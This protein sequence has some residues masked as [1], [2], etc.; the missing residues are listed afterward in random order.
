[1]A[2]RGQDINGLV[3]A[4]RAGDV[5][6]R[7]FLI[8]ALAMGF[9]LPVARAL[10]AQN[11]AS[12]AGGAPVSRHVALAQEPKK[13][14]QVIVGL[15]QEPTKFNP[16]ISTLEVDRGVQFAVFDSLWRIGPD[17]L[18]IPNLATEVPTLDNG[19]ISPDALTYTFKLRQD[20]KWHDGTPLTARDVIFT[21]E[22]IMDPNIPSPLKLGHDK[23]ASIEA[24]DDYT[25]TLTLTEPYAPFLIIWGDTYIV[26]EHILKDQDFMTSEFTSM[27]P[28]GSGPFIFA[29]RTAGEA[30]T[31]EANPNYHGPGPYLDKL[32]FKYIQDT[33][34]LYTQFKTGEI[35]VTGIQFITANHLE[36]A[37][38]LPGKVIHLGQSA[39]V[40]FIYPNFGNP[41]L[42]DKAVREAMYY[43]MDK[44]GIINAIYYGVHAPAE[45][46]LAQT[47]WAYNPNLPKHEYNPDKAR[48]VLDAAGWAPGDDGIRQKDGLRLS[49]RNS[50]T[51]GNALRE[52][53][54]QYL[55]QTW[56]D[57]GIE[58]TIENFP[59]AVVWG[60][61]YNKSQ[62]DTVMIG[63]IAGPGGD[64]DV[65]TRFHSSQIPVETGAG[66]N[67]K[68]YKNPE[69][70]RLLEEGAREPDQE[71]RKQIYFRV[72]EI[73]RED[74]AVL[75]IFHYVFIEGTKEG[76][77][78]FKQNA[79]VV[80]N[81]WNVYEWYWA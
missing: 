32:I 30:I 57:V 29:S 17:G 15:T 50:T 25:I 31:L 27:K 7:E 78:N 36:E 33:E 56:K 74:L 13:G 52:Q 44:E 5:S 64:P 11:T 8:R 9:S 49:F 54:Q 14:G 37:K 1:M 41:V 47:S 61:F 76:L 26:P 59:P 42:A 77:Q 81:E 4:L 3:A 23:V 28:V 24:P 34:V 62:Y 71:K 53:A 19:G 10:I 21:H 40:E 67:T 16:V 18:F 2:G 58:M 38:T 79:F 39:F 73:I 6:R 69:V 60:D 35:D 43:A 68:R 63:D 12:A 65:M 55:Q 22:K 20:A 51:A 45:T 80:S 70:D 75:P 48:E 72:Q 66:Q 46:F